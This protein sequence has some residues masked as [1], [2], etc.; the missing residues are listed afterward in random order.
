MNYRTNRFMH[1]IVWAV[2][3]E[4]KR[5]DESKQ[6]ASNPNTYRHLSVRCAVYRRRRVAI[7]RGDVGQTDKPLQDYSELI[8]NL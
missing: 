4:P 2:K 5:K 1:Y 8:L 3:Q 7:E 6:R